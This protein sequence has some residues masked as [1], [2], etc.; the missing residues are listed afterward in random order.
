MFSGMT[1]AW[2]IIAETDLV[3][4]E[5]DA[6]PFREYFV[7]ALPHSDQAVESLRMRKGLSETKLTVVVGE[8]T[9]T[10]IENFNIKDGE[11]F[12][13]GLYAT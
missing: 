8:A 4:R 3:G 5:S 13:V 6:Q 2:H 10:F 9:L 1:M 11:I 7:V 12:S